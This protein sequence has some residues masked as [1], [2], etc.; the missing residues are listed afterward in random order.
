MEVAK[1]SEPKS[2]DFFIKALLFSSFLTFGRWE[3]ISYIKVVQKSKKITPIG[4]ERKKYISFGTDIKY[5]EAMYAIMPRKLINKK[6]FKRNLYFF[7]ISNLLI[8]LFEIKKLSN[9]ITSKKIVANIINLMEG[10]Y[11]NLFK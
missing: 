2:I 5:L 6:I 4:S 10:L 3:R 7:E 1:A 11:T 9:P 8:N